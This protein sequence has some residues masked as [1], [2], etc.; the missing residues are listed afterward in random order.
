MINNTSDTN[1]SLSLGRGLGRGAEYLSSHGI[2][3]T[4]VRL[5]VWKEANGY[6]HKTF[7]LNDIETAMP[8]MDRSSIFRALRLFTEH[9]LLHEI[10]D[11][12]G[13]QKYCVCRCEGGHH[14]GHVHF[15][16]TQCGQTFCLESIEIPSINLPEGVEVEEVE[17]IIKGKCPACKN[18]H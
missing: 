7:T 9:H 4:A 18:K 16:C 1:H 15:T 14:K 13:F 17:Y 12:S 5:L 6:R 3:P 10:S 11:G 2:R 8:H